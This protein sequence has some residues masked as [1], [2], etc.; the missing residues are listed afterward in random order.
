MPS[1][2][3][4]KSPYLGNGLTS[5]HEI[6]HDGGAVWPSWAFRPLKFQKFQNPRWRRPL[7]WKIAISQRRFDWLPRNLARWCSST[8]FRHLTVKTWSFKTP[9]WCRSPY[10]KIEKNR[11]EIFAVAGWPSWPFRPSYF[12]PEVEIRQF[13]TCTLK[14]DTVGHN[15]LGY[16][17]DTTERIS[18]YHYYYCN[19][20]LRIQVALE[21]L[22]TEKLINSY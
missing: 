15:A 4:K 12:S 13:H 22:L 16:G 3:V 18:S 20:H 7:S 1:W 8:L 10:W 6:W 11:H 2:V 14:N 21:K 19:L 9:R 5:R 17:A